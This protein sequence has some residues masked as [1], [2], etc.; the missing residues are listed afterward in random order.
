M[1]QP[2]EEIKSRLDIVEIIREYVPLKPAGVNFKAKCPFHNEKTPSFIVSP[3][4]QIWHCFGCGRGGDVFSF[5]MEAEGLSFVEALRWLAP[6]AGVKLRRFSSARASQR[7]RLLDLLDLAS[8]YYHQVLLKSGQAKPARDYLAKRG[9]EPETIS[10]WRLG[11]SP[12]SWQAA[13]DFLKSKGYS[14]AEI[15]AAG[16]SIKK[17]RAQGYYDRFRARIMFPL[18]DI[19][20][21]VVGFA[22]R[23]NPDR[24]GQEKAGKYINTPQ[25]L[26]YDKSKLLFGLDKAKLAIKQQDLAIIV[27]GQMDVIASHQAGFSNTI[28]SSGTALTAEQIKLIKRYS[29]NIALAFDRDEA[30]LMALERASAA[31]LAAGLNISVIKIPAG[32]DPDECLRQDPQ[33]WQKAVDQAQPLLAYFFQ[34]VLTPAALAQPT[35]RQQAINKLLSILALVANPLDQDYWLKK[36]SQQADAE[37]SI[38]REQ[39]KIAINRRRPSQSAD[40][41]V[42]QPAPAGGKEL[43][44]GQKQSARL[45]ALLFAEPKIIEKTIS[46]LTVDCLE[47]Q[48]HKALYKHLIL[49]YNKKSPEILKSAASGQGG[50]FFLDFN[51]WLKETLTSNSRRLAANFLPAEKG[52][53][54]SK[55]FAQLALLGE[56]EFYDFTPEQAWREAE[57]L[58][59]YLKQN[60]YRQRLK[61]LSQLISQLEKQVE[62]GQNVEAELNSLLKEFKALTDE[63]QALG[64]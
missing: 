32:K 30:G 8:R 24:E 21:N 42:R 15:F 47:G 26:V 2:S 36:L 52:P 54:L 4:K 55:V 27:E 22:G 34:E 35:T 18:F 16:L 56:S 63:K 19:N 44:R 59:R 33:Q 3:E 17:E 10:A 1:L 20:S 51:Q 60:Y 64:L 6:K 29:K 53:D 58:I 61:E 57:S 49:Y 62:Q 7:N 46:A 43:S 9:L 39:L 37:E 40:S 28:A 38:L 31:A 25:T 45:L 13:L 12:D 23:L 41:A 50:Q 11:Y 14:E 5:I 48:A